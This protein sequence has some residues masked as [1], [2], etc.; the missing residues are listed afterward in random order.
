MKIAYADPP[1]VGCAARHYKDHPDYAGEVD[2][3]ALIER[4]NEFD[5]WALSLHSPSLKT[6]LPLCPDDSRVGAWVK[7]WSVWKP[8]VTVAYA[9]E[10]VIFRGGR[11]RRRSELTER[12]WVSANAVMFRRN[13]KH[14]TKGSKPEA[15]CFWLFEVLGMQP[16]DEFHDLFPGS[17]AVGRAWEAWRNQPRLPIRERKKET[18]EL[19]WKET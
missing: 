4:L 3:V 2:H 14:Q 12:D 17:G 5:A 9:W 13:D 6:I 1:Y 16:G 18:R 10:P 11:K 7:P 8:G 15:F 19:L